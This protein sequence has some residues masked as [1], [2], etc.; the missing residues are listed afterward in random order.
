M[1]AT[2]TAPD[3]SSDAPPRTWSTRLAA[4]KG[5]GVSERDPRI[6]R[7]REALSYWRTRRVIDAEL[8]TLTADDRADLAQR[9]T[10]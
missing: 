3:R 1:S 8:S 7:C 9:L 2:D 5:R 10:T 4:Y 6:Q